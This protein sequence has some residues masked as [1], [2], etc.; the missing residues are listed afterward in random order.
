MPSWLKDSVFYEIYPQSF[1][2]TNGDGIGDINGITEKLDYIKGLGC[3]AIWIN[4]IY[5][6]PFHDAGYDVRD[7][8]KVAPRYGTLKDVK[9][10]LK[11][12]HKRDMRIIFD[13]IPGHTSDEHKWFRSAQKVEKNEYSD[14]YVFTNSVW[15][16]PDGYK[17]VNGA[18]QR[19]GNYL[20]NFFV[21]QPALN[22]GFN[23]ITDPSWQMS[24]KD[25]RCHKTLE[26]M[27]DVM[28][29]WLDIGVDGF[30]VDMAD[31]LVKNDDEKLAT[32]SLWKEV[33]IWLE[34]EY[35][36]AAMVA[37]W[38]HPYR[39]IVRGGFHMDFYLD[40]QGNGY[41]A[42][43]RNIKDGVNKS[44]FCKDGKGDIKEFLNQYL[45]TMEAL[46]GEGYYCF[47]TCNHDT[48]RPTFF[49]DNQNIKLMQ[50]F[51]MTMP[52]V[53]FVYYGDEI[54]MKYIEGMNSVE[55][56]YPRTGTRTPMQWDST[57][58][59]GFSSAP[60][61]KL[62]IQQD[63][64][65]NAPTVEKQEGKKGSILENLKHY[66]KLRKEN[67]ELANDSLFEVVYAEKDKYPFV[68]RRGKFTIFV[69][70][71]LKEQAVKYETTSDEKVFDVLGTYKIT[72]KKVYVGPQSFI[73]LK[74]E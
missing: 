6:S 7:Y 60:K 51:I 48:P 32:S 28:K 46:N 4:P 24:F 54:G 21:N 70:P 71:S 41:H 35:P 18:A 14:R 31:S 16:C 9:R 8:K 15:D 63:L 2:D 47:I 40:H 25:P 64:S 3:N 66:T 37:E 62:Y 13:L 5:D 34:K 33:R 44:F 30:R 22:Y 36:E 50:A 57:K 61:N 52:G 38:S 23:N 56:G 17:W 67:I 27:M 69:N 73:I 43:F 58:N 29:Y 72:K 20:I 10:M 55:G 42:L 12:A 49:M 1:N 65:K 68:Y 26:A 45:P 59:Y 53:P 74:T 19:D 39:A 11:E